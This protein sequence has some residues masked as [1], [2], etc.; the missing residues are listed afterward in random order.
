MYF[1]AITWKNVENPEFKP[2][3]LHDVSLGGVGLL[4]NAKIHEPSLIA[5]KLYQEHTSR[6][7]K[8]T[9]L[10][11]RSNEQF[12]GPTE[13][14]AAVGIKFFEKDEKNIRELTMMIEH[15]EMIKNKPPSITNLIDEKDR[16]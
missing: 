3:F 12:F 2:C 13:K 6:P 10:L 1:F 5:V 8:M 7:V 14:Y 9:G 16:N 11:V 4:I 15:L